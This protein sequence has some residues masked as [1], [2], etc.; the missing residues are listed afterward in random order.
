MDYGVV[1]GLQFILF[2][3]AALGFPLWQIWSCRPDRRA[4]D[5]ALKPTQSPNDLSP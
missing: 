4:P 3:G 5:P 2:F 1:K